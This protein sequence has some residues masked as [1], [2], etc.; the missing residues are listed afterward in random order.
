M[1]APT[2][3]STTHL[4][5]S[6]GVIGKFPKTST[7]F[8]RAYAVHTT[9]AISLNIISAGCISLSF[10]PIASSASSISKKYIIYILKL[11]ST[12]H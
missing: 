8:G 5:A 3:S 11:S 12:I 4:S 9:K 6:N 2:Y 10:E 7:P 1:T